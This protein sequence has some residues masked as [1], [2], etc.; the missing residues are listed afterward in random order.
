[1]GDYNPSDLVAVCES[2]LE[3]GEISGD[4]LY[5]LA[6]WLND[7]REAC[8]HWPGDLL[9]K[10]LQDVWADGKVT[11]TEMRQIGRLLVRICKEWAKRLA[12]AA[13]EHAADT[14]AQLAHAID[15]SQPRMPAIPFVLRVKSHTDTGVIYDV[16]LSGPSC[17]C[18]DWRS[19]RYALPQAHLSRCCKHVF[20]AYGQVEP[21]D[22]WP[23][24]LGAFLDLSWTPHPQ[25]DWMVLR[26]GRGFV[27][28]STAPTG[29]ANV[30]AEEGGIYDR[31]GYNVFEDRWAYG[32]EPTGSDRICRAIADATNR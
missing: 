14:A 26:I 9:V 16:D 31:F 28:A 2:I 21:E 18:P 7:H 1:M 6:E 8:F 32:M 30:Y 10:P 3:D 27:L 29:W 19:K 12:E 5:R 13:F 4:E 22:G 25:Q 20:D 23:S 11:K 17:T 15:L 24:W